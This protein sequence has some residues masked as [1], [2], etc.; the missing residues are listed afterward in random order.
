MLEIYKNKKVLITGHTGFKGS[1]LSCILEVLGAKQ[2]GY[3]LAP[4][5]Q[6]S[7]FQL[8]NLDHKSIIED[9]SNFEKL[10]I[11]IQEFQPDIIFHLAAQPLV[12]DSYKNPIN[13]YQTNVMGTANLLQSIMM[14][15]SS[16]WTVVITTDK[17][18]KNDNSGRAFIETDALEGKDPYSASKVGTESVVAAWQQIAKVSGGPS[19]VS[20]R[21]LPGL[22]P[23]DFHRNI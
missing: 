10:S 6:P 11:Q 18:Y 2:I 21:A 12:I 19:V 9:I 8:L 3:S 17:V 7:H 16:P 14:N 20:V 15:K 22:S 4:N 13:T 23:Q 1:W 5:T